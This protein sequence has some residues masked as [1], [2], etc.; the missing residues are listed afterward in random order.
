MEENKEQ[1]VLSYQP[2]EETHLH[3]VQAEPFVIDP[4]ES[5]LPDGF[6][7]LI[8]GPLVWKG[9]EVASK[10]EQWLLQLSEEDVKEIK[11]AMEVFLGE[12]S[13]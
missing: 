11:G 13:T 6:P 4:N 7:E 1:T 3:R 12:H 9:E 8:S 10:P 2:S 5:Y